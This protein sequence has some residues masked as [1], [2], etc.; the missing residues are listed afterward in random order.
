MRVMGVGMNMLAS[1]NFDDYI[2]RTNK[3]GILCDPRVLQ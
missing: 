3:K 1:S 2:Y